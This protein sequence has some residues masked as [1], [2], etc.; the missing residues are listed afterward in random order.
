MHDIL[1]PRYGCIRKSEG[2]LNCYM[3][4]RD[5]RRNADGRRR[6]KVI[7]NSAIPYKPTETAVSR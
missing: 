3:Y 5:R 1:N 2:C 4:P 7:T 6:H